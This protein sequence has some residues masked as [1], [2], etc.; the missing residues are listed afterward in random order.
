VLLVSWTYHHLA[1]ISYVDHALSIRSFFG[2]GCYMRIH[3][4]EGW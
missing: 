2:G 1:N 4:S 3:E